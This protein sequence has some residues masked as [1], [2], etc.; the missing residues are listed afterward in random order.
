MTV[1]AVTDVC[2]PQAAH[3]HK[4]RRAS[5][6]AR[7][8][9]QT[10]QRYPSGQR[11]PASYSKASRVVSEATLKLHDAAREAGPGHAAKLR[12]QPDGTG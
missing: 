9:P 3:S 11:D 12:P 1:P 7:V 6:H 8:P 10:G 4:C 2:T 5:T